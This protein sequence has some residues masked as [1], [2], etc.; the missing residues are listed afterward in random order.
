MTILLITVTHSLGWAFVLNVIGDLF[1]DGRQFLRLVL[2]LGRLLLPA[3]VRHVLAQRELVLL[4]DV[5]QAVLVDVRGA[6][7]GSCRTKHYERSKL[8]N[9][10]VQSFPY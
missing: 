3:V 7:F 6:D 5:F 1:S 10:Y 8:S 9:V 4:E 2:T